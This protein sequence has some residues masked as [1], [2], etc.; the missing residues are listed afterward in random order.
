LGTRPSSRPPIGVLVVRKDAPL[1]T[2][3]L[4]KALGGE[5]TIRL[6]ATPLV[7]EAAIEHCRRQRPD[8]LLIEATRMPVPS[9]PPL[10]ARITEACGRPPAVLVADQDVTDAFFVSGVEAGAYAILDGS[11]TADDV[12]RAVHAAAAREPLIDRNRLMTAVQVA[13]R[14]REEQRRLAQRIALLTERERE[15]LSCLVEGLRNSDIAYRLSISPRTVEKHVHHILNKLGVESRL[16]A[17]AR[18]SHVQQTVYGGLR[19]SM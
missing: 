3:I 6:L 19:G 9:I 7:I 2:E 8:V 14:S 4:A 11:A 13:A 10:V 17:A 16:A 5:P 1:F 12:V 18:A 15:V